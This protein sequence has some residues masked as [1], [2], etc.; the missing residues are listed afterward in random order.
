MQTLSAIGAFSTSINNLS[1]GTDYEFR[2]VVT[3]SDGDTATGSIQMF[4]TLATRNA[5]SIDQFSVS[6]SG[7]PNPHAEISISWQ[8]ADADADLRTVEI[9]ISNES[10]QRMRTSTTDVN[11]ESASGTD[12]FKIKQGGGTTYDCTLTVTDS[13]SQTAS[14]I[15]T[16]SA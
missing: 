11:G 6:E 10:G 7:S 13:R 2:A 12:S 5:P 1:S 4:T 15:E 3:A 9:G 14:Q 16:V 8:E